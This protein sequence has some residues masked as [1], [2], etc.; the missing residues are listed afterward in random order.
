[1]FCSLSKSFLQNK[2]PI[3]FVSVEINKAFQR[4]SLVVRASLIYKTKT[5]LI[6]GLTVNIEQSISSE[7]LRFVVPAD[8]IYKKKTPM[9][10]CLVTSNKAFE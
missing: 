8:L 10:S 6:L 3:D 5:P 7:G 9:I 1:M 4:G 2:D